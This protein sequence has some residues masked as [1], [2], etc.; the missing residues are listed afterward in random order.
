[1]NKLSETV[2]R[3][4]RLLLDEDDQQ[5]NEIC[6]ECGQSVRRGSGKFINRV[7][8]LNGYTTR[9]EMGKPHPEGDYICADC[10]AELDDGQP[11]EVLP[12]PLKDNEMN[13][14]QQ[15]M[16]LRQLIEERL[17]NLCPAAERQRSFIWKQNSVPAPCPNCA[18][19]VNVIEAGNLNPDEP[20][21]DRTS[22]ED[23]FCPKCKR[24]LLFVV[25]FFPAGAAW[26]VWQLVPEKL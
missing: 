4:G 12:F 14:E 5:G 19:P 9:R 15:R 18:A 13:T 16:T 7:I 2:F 8:D 25:P 24:Q 23:Y 1:M 3:N 22:D 26:Y 6:N 20:P 17:P 10:E 21:P 11:G